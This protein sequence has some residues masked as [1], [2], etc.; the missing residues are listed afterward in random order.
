MAAA[1]WED[2][3]APRFLPGTFARARISEDIDG[4]V[5]L[6]HWDWCGWTYTLSYWHNGEYCSATLYGWELR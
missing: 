2:T 6:I 3:P 1:P 4:L 5:T